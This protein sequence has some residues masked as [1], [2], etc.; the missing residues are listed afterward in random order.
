MTLRQRLAL[1]LAAIAGGFIL[2]AWCLY[3][4]KEQGFI[5]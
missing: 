5:P 1:A 4:A 3:T 2:I